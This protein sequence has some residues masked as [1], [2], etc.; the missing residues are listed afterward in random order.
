M[1]VTMMSLVISDGSWTTSS[2][3]KKTIPTSLKQLEANKK[4]IPV[5]STASPNFG[6]MVER[7]PHDSTLAWSCLT[8]VIK[9]VFA[10][11]SFLLALRTVIFS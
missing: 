11:I 9:S 10:A 1:M 4:A 3:I 2:A 6:W 5:A 8:R 7:V